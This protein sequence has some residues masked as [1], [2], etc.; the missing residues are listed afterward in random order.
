MYNVVGVIKGHWASSRHPL[1][2][3]VRGVKGLCDKRP[4][5]LAGVTG[6]F[7]RTTSSIPRPESP[8]DARGRG[9]PPA[10]PPRTWSRFR[11]APPMFK[12]AQK[13]GLL[14]IRAVHRRGHDRGEQSRRGLVLVAVDLGVARARRIQGDEH[15]SRQ[16]QRNSRQGQSPVDPG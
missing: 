15:W 5:R 16:A 10:W 8:R 6:I 12:L 3:S 13:I 14:P 4:L 11:Y 7:G 1:W 9:R 2:G